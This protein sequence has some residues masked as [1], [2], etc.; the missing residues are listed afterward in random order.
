MAYDVELAEAL[1]RHLEGTPGLGERK[2]FG[3]L[4]FLINGNMAVAAS[5][6]GGALLRTDPDENERYL[7]MDH[8]ESAVM[9]GRTMRG[10]LRADT[11]RLG[12]AF[13]PLVGEAVEHAQSLPAK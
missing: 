13:W 5:K 3:G 7:A 1:T 12:D 2:M 6:D 9:G 8:V 11:D 4:A 10:W